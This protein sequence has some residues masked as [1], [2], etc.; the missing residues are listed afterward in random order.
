MDGNEI[1][2]LREAHKMTQAQL[3]QVIG[4][5]LRTVGNWETGSTVPK[6][7]LGMLRQF[8]GVK[9]DGD[10]DPLRAATDVTLL[11]EL[12]RRAVDRENRDA[13]AG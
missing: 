10:D 8:F 3:A 7:R 12:L 9:E 6:N 13:A 4:V 5:G 11:T 1:R 2:R